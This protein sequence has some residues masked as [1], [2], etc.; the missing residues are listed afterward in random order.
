MAAKIRV[1]PKCRGHNSECPHCGGGG[2]DDA[3]RGLN[4]IG[5][6]I[7]PPTEGLSTSQYAKRVA[8]NKL[9]KKLAE[10]GAERKEAEGFERSRYEKAERVKKILEQLK[11]DR[12]LRKEQ[13]ENSREQ[14]ERDRLLKKHQAE[15][16]RKRKERDRV[17]KKKQAKKCQ[18]Q[19]E[20]DWLERNKEAKKKD[21]KPKR[22]RIKRSI[23]RNEESEIFERGALTRVPNREDI[24]R[25]EQIAPE[26]NEDAI[27]RA[28]EQ[29][30]IASRRRQLDSFGRIVDG[31]GPLKK[32]LNWWN[33]MVWFLIGRK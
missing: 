5:S 23:D 11:K 18:Q 8:R 12:Q 24:E 14:R 26:V 25:Q 30:S 10:K 20:R 16:N 3:R 2:A 28:P 32:P 15:N 33:K 29:N 9:A 19:K 17:T 1:C 6:R 4:V 31:S 13:V 21:E 7:K 22:T 27:G